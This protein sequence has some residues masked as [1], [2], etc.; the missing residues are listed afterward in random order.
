MLL[1]SIEEVL[2][3]YIRWSHENTFVCV[4]VC[5]MVLG[6]LLANIIRARKEHIRQP[7]I[8]LCPDFLSPYSHACARTHT[9]TLTHTHIHTQVPVSI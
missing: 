6:E 5:V 9:H 7:H 4:C 3:P 2:N 8:C 1:W